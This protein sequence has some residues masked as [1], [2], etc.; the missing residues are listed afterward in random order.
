MR[1]CAWPRGRL[2]RACR[3]LGSIDL[4]SRLGRR[5]S[6]VEEHKAAGVSLDGGLRPARLHIG[7]QSVN[8]LHCSTG[9]GGSSLRIEGFMEDLKLLG[10]L[11]VLTGRCALVR[12]HQPDVVLTRTK[13]RELF[14]RLECIAL[15]DG[16]VHPVCVLYGILLGVAV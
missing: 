3:P 6:Y 5:S 14:L 13:V 8:P 12:D 11:R 2:R 9:F 4:R 16:S 15:A 10:C 1:R 7:V